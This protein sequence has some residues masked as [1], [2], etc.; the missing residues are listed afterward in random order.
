MT[1][2]YKKGWRDDPGN[3]RPVSLPSVLGK[4]TG[5]IIL[6]VIMQG[7]QAIRPSQHGFSKGSSCSRNQISFYD[8]VTCSLDDGR[9]VDVVYLDFSKAL[10]TISR[11]MLLE[12][13][14]AQSLIWC[15]LHWV[16]IWLSGQTQR[17]VVNGVPFQ[18]EASH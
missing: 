10:E 12:E 17:V 1:F 6:S 2:I 13:L 4:L 16:K 14:H 11:S 5:Q 18:L 9:S 3:Y 8:K 7:N 15:T